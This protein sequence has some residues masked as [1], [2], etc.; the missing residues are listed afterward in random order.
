RLVARRSSGS[1]GPAVEIPEPQA[2]ALVLYRGA[3]RRLYHHP[4]PPEAFALLSALGCGLSLIGAC[5][6]ALE[7]WPEHA[8]RLQENVAGWFQDWAR[9]GWIVDVLPRV[10]APS[11]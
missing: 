7:R 10:E 6:S 1:A 3:D 8:A 2:Q 11:T 5:E 4:V 9:R